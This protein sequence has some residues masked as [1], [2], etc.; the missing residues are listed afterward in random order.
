ME[1][2]GGVAFHTRHISNYLLIHPIVLFGVPGGKITFNQVTAHILKRVLK[3]SGM[4]MKKGVCA[5]GIDAFKS[6][7]S[8]PQ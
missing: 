5:D 1:K 3:E 4:H 7:T 2:W 8:G 6:L